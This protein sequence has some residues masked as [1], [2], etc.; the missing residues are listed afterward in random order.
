LKQ[1]KA[2]QGAIKT[3]ALNHKQIFGLAIGKSVTSDKFNSKYVILFVD[4][5]LY[6][7]AIYEN[8]NHRKKGNIFAAVL[9]K[10]N[11]TK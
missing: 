10:T 6:R 11:Q 5:A 1:T 2:P 8:N 7:L 4:L 3:R 9:S